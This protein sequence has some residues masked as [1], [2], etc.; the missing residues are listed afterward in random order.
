MIYFVFVVSELLAW[1]NKKSN[2]C[3]AFLVIFALFVWGFNVD[4]ADYSNYELAYNSLF[5]EATEPVYLNVFHLFGL[6]IGLPFRLFRFLW[7]AIGISLIA[8]T[9]YKYSKNPA[10]VLG[11]YL[12][13]PFVVDVIQMRSFLA[14]SIVIFSSR[15][16]FKYQE[17][18]RFKYIVF[19]LLC[20][21]LA[22]GIHYSSVMYVV[23]L[24]LFF[25]KRAK[26]YIF[27]LVVPL[28]IV[29]VILCIP[30]LRPIIETVIG[31]Q[32]T[33]LWLAGRDNVTLN[34]FIKLLVTR[35]G[36]IILCVLS[37]KL[38]KANG[39]NDELIRNNNVSFDNNLFFLISEYCFLF[40]FMEL[41]WSTQ[42]ERMVRPGILFAN[43]NISNCLECTEKNNK[44]IM[45]FITILFNVFYFVMIMFKTK[46]KATGYTWFNIVFINVMENIGIVK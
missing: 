39:Y 46:D 4:N 21:L 35:G 5:F 28:L 1:L 44:R 33:D 16:I 37:S 8:T 45:I 20:I 34:N 19:F 40:V 23:L 11:M 31:V 36:F 24:P 2:I 14:S 3:F 6:W 17:N 7:G 13:Y 22:M 10:F 9:V 15:F 29:L 42:F 26:K 12:L 18:N 41:L 38:K 27:L 25:Y 30:L 43:I 32:K